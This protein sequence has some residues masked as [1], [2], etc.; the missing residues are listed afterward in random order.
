MPRRTDAS[1]DGKRLEVHPPRGLHHRVPQLGRSNLEAVA[2][3]WRWASPD[4]DPFGFAQLKHPISVDRQH[5]PGLHPV[6]GVLLVSEGLTESEFR[7]A[8]IRKRSRLPTVESANKTPS[9]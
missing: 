4:R 3:A 9:S 7:C 1:G 8:L 6:L 5:D 2:L